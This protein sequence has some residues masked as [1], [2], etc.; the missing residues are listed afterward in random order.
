MK[1]RD[2]IYKSF[3]YSFGRD[4][5]LWHQATSHTPSGTE[6]CTIDQGTCVQ[7]CVPQPGHGLQPDFPCP[8]SGAHPKSHQDLNTPATTK[9]RQ[10]TQLPRIHRMVCAQ[11]RM[12]TRPSAK[13]RLAAGEFLSTPGREGRTGLRSPACTAPAEVRE[14][15][16]LCPKYLLLHFTLVSFSLSAFTP[17]T[18]GTG[19]QLHTGSPQPQDRKVSR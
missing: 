16:P 15:K 4:T 9:V 1:V 8:T 14:L 5:L 2:L 12:Q 17:S 19:A 10:K 3:S 11:F 13:Q 7:A 18:T 6:H